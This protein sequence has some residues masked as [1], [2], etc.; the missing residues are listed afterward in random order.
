MVRASPGGPSDF[1]TTMKKT[2]SRQTTP[3]Q[4][5]VLQPLYLQIKHMLIQRVPPGKW[6]RAPGFSTA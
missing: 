1:F 6:R 2:G 4:R 5:P 3:E